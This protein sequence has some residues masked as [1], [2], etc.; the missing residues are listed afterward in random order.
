MCTRFTIEMDEI[1]ERPEEVFFV[2]LDVSLTQRVEFDP[3]RTQIVIL[4]D[5][6]ELL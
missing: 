1:L 5:D 2:R 6:S 3:R 4:D